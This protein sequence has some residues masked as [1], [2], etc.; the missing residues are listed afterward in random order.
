MRIG[1]VIF[2]GLIACA[3]QSKQQRPHVEGRDAPPGFST[4]D[5]PA[6][7]RERKVGA[8]KQEFF[9]FR[10]LHEQLSALPGPDGVPVVIEKQTRC[11]LHDEPLQPD[12]VEVIFGFPLS[13][14]KDV[15]LEKQ[16]FP[17]ARDYLHGGCVA[18][19]P[20]KV[21]LTFCPKCRMEKKAWLAKQGQQR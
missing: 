17:F 10:N 20:K 13:D 3:A 2:V 4:D 14:Q 9:V 8:P 11:P 16:A 21:K 5:Q 15:D 12:T 6:S 1:G 7:A 18:R 19:E